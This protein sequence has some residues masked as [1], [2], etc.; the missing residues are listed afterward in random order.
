MR[1]FKNIFM[2]VVA[3]EITMQIKHHILHVAKVK[4][5]TLAHPMADVIPILAHLRAFSCKNRPLRFWWKVDCLN[6]FYTS[7][8][9]HPMKENGLYFARFAFF[10]FCPMFG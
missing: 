7:Q 9:T 4:V 2:T 5:A 6:F 3:G 10:V 8:A 1:K